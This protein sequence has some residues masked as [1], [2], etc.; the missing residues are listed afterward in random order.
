FTALIV[1]AACIPVLWFLNRRN[2]VA[3]SPY[4]L[5][6]LVMWVA[7]LKSGVHATRAGVIAAQFIPLTNKNDPDHSPLKRLEHDLHSVVAYFVLPV[8][9]FANAGISLIGVGPEQLMHGVPLGIALGLIVGKQVG[10]F[11]LCGLAIKL[12]LTS[13]PRGMSW[14]NLYGTAALC[15]V[16]FTMSLFIGSLAFEASG[17]NLLF[18]ERL[19]IIVGSLVS[20]IAGFFVLRATL[21][22]DASAHDTP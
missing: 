12:G 5:I 7:T 18:D 22:A 3:I 21:P 11:G 14:S 4:I 17:E 1:A 9:A 15:G 10:I 16:G 19:G 13:L 20:G 8:F 6:A 2:V